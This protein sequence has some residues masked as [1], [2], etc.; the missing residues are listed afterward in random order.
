MVRFPGD[1]IRKQP[2]F[3]CRIEPLLVLLQ[4]LDERWIEGNAIPRIIGL[5]V[6]DPTVNAAALNQQ[7]ERLKIK[8]RPLQR[9]NFADAKAQ[10]A[11]HQDHGSVWLTNQ[12]QQRVIPG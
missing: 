10:T 8:V 2:P 1:R 4:C 11:S 7:R 9:H 3:R 6:A 5:H 12:R